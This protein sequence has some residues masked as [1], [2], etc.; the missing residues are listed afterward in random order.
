MAFVTDYRFFCPVAAVIS[1]HPSTKPSFL[2][3]VG[4]ASLI[5][6]Q[7]QEEHRPSNH[8]TVARPSSFH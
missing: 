5:R 7:L 8:I 3:V 1:K 2:T 6:L 4:L